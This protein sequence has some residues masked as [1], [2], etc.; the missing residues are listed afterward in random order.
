M[1]ASKFSVVTLINSSF[2]SDSSRRR[3]ARRLTPPLPSPP[4]GER[5]RRNL[6]LFFRSFLPAF[7]LSRSRSRSRSHSHSHSGFFL[8]VI[9]CAADRRPN[10]GSVGTASP[11]P[12]PSSRR[13]RYAAA[14]LRSVR[15]LSHSPVF[16]DSVSVLRSTLK[17]RAS[18]PP[19][20]PATPRATTRRVRF[21]VGDRQSVLRINANRLRLYSS[22]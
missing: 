17:L 3:L 22:P 6:F 8:L 21:A 10:T 2:D 13:A 4:F 5:T 14:N 12:S 16:P 7:V 20:R 1:P 11:S 15:V 9:L 19:R 18:L